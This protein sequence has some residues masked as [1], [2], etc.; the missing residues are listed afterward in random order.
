MR[1]KIFTVCMLA[2]TVL[3][4]CG[5]DKIPEN[6]TIGLSSFDEDLFPQN[7]TEEPAEADDAATT[8]SSEV[9][10]EIEEEESLD[11]EVGKGEIALS[12]GEN[13]FTAAIDVELGTKEKFCSFV[14]DLDS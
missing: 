13:E 6:S 10:K 4:A 7:L 8:A 5:K 9:A 11:I 12:F 1:K 3:S 14:V 2:A